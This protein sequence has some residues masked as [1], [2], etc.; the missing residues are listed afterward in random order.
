VTVGDVVL[1]GD[2]LRGGIIGSGA[3]THFFMCDLEGNRRDVKRVFTQLAPE[4]QVV[5]VGHFGP[6][7]PD[8]VRAHFE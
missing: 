4:A 7:T 2:L 1:V 8:A 3:E 6:V 5:F